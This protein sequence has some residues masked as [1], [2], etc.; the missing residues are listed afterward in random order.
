M[1]FT[2]KR[3]RKSPKEVFKIVGLKSRHLSASRDTN[4]FFTADGIYFVKADANGVAIRHMRTLGNWTMRAFSERR[5][6]SSVRLKDKD[7][8]A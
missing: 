8:I 5:S 3:L 7:S 6:P 2:E 4:Y 1:W